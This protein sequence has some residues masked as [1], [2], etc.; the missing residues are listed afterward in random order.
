MGAVKPPVRACPISDRA[1][2]DGVGFERR[3]RVKERLCYSLG[4]VRVVLPDPAG[5]VLEVLCGGT[6]PTDLH[7][8]RKVRSTAAHTSSGETKSPRS[9]AASP[10]VTASAKRASSSRY[11]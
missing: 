9:A 10:S 1:A 6:G 7:Y 5:D 8:K 2:R 3:T 4:S 11:W